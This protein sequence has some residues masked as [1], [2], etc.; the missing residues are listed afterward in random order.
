MVARLRL[1][2]DLPD[3]WITWVASVMHGT[4][5][6]HGEHLQVCELRHEAVLREEACQA[7]HHVCS[8]RAVVV[9][10]ARLV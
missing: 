3:G 2:I 4:G 8:M 1:N 7:L 10:I 9:R 6:D 5:E